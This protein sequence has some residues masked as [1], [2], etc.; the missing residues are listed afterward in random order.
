MSKTKS[1]DILWHCT[2]CSELA[3]D[4]F[5]VLSGKEMQKAQKNMRASDELSR[6]GSY[7]LEELMDLPK[8]GEW[9]CYCR[10]H[11]L[12]M[13]DD[14]YYFEVSRALSFKDL[15]DWTFHLSN[16]NWFAS[17]DW[18]SFIRRRVLDDID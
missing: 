7:S 3:Y 11:A 9:H 17:T 18:Q 6:K 14:G 13:P 15:L 12:E 5:I 8:Q 2:T 4:G 10:K 1:P 16:K